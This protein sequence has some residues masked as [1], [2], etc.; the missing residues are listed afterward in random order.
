MNEVAQDGQ[1]LVLCGFERQ[2][3]GVLDPKTHA[4]M[5]GPDDFH[6]SNPASVAA[7]ASRLQFFA[8]EK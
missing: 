1:R 4:Q 6:I 3:N 5:F 2:R 7:D 8:E